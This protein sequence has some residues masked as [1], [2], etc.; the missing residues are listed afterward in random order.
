MSIVS[1]W[2]FIFLGGCLCDFSVN[3]RRNV[4]GL[5]LLRVALVGAYSCTERGYLYLL[6]I[7]PRSFLPSPLANQTPSFFLSSSCRQTKHKAS[8]L[9]FIFFFVPSSSQSV[10]STVLQLVTALPYNLPGPYQCTPLY[11]D[12]QL[13]KTGETDSTSI[14]F[15]QESL[16][17]FTHSHLLQEIQDQLRGQETPLWGYCSV[18]WCRRF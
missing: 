6:F 16:L 1:F 11:R 15:V 9:V 12:T 2:S 4:Q 14:H 13:G 5:S 17:D 10:I 8:G 18:L 3:F 7:Y